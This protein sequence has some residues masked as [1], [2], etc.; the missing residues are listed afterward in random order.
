MEIQSFTI[1]NELLNEIHHQA[2]QVV[3]Q[4]YDSVKIEQMSQVICKFYQ[5]LNENLTVNSFSNLT[6]NVV[7]QL[8]RY[9]ETRL[10]G[11]MYNSIHDQIVNENEQQDLSLETHISSLNRIKLI[12]LQLKVDLDNPEIGDLLEKSISHLIEMGSKKSPLQKLDSIVN[13]SKTIIRM[14]QIDSTN[15]ISADELLPA[16]IYVIIKANP[17]TIKSDIKF[18]EQFSYSNHLMSGES[19][20]YFTNLCCALIFIENLDGQSLNLPGKKFLPNN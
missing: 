1:S 4:L 19:G 15:H 5:K 18:I 12:D 2:A 6:D 11:P 8:I 3:D 20:Y 7:N 9:I 10:L 13:C 17:A 16:L 14:L